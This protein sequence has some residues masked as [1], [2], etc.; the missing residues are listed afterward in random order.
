MVEPVF[1]KFLHIKI[2]MF[3]RIYTKVYFGPF[4][5]SDASFTD[6]ISHF[7][8]NIIGIHQEFSGHSLYLLCN[9]FTLLLTYYL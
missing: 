8:Y 2:C 5:I 6:A 1:N 7:K 3:N 4:L 9:T